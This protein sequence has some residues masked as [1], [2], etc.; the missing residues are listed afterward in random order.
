MMND[1]L[2]NQAFEEA[3]KAIKAKFANDRLIAQDKYN[4]DVAALDKKAE[5]KRIADAEKAAKELKD[6]QDRA[7]DSELA[8]TNQYYTDKDDILK[9]QLANNLITQE[10]YDE[11]QKQNTIAQLEN[12]IQ[13]YKDAGKS[14]IAL[15]RQLAEAKKEIRDADA[16]DARQ[17][18]V[19]TAQFAIDQAKIGRA[20]V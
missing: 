10:Q 14:T 18:A 5:D 9:T 20:H 15:E 6:F 19:D 11:L 7:F 13:I 1:K 12:L 3:K 8:A 17:K 4:N 16:A 2:L